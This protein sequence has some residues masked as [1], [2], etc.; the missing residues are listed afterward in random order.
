MKG[1][2]DRVKTLLL[3]A[4][5]AKWQAV[6]IDTVLRGL[7][8]IQVERVLS[9]RWHNHYWVNKLIGR[10]YAAASYIDDWIE[11][12]CDAPQL[13]VDLCN[14]SNLV[15]YTRAR[16]A[17]SEYPL[18]I[19]SHSA[20]GDDMA[21][22]RRTAA[23]FQARRGKLLVFVGNEY[24]LMPTKIGFLNTVQADY[25]GCQL[26][27][28]AAQFLY[29]ECR[30]TQILMTPHALNPKLYYPN[31]TM[32][33]TTDIGFIGD[34]YPY[35][36]G[37]MERTHII[38]Y[39]QEHAAELGLNCDIRFRR[40]QSE[41]WANFLRQCKGI[42]GAEAGTYY[43]ERNDWTIQAVNAYLKEHPDATFAEV[44][45]R[46][47]KNHPRTI[48]GKAISSRHFEPIGTQTCQVLLEGRYNDILVA[49][50]HYIGIKKD[51]S[52]VQEAI[53]RFKDVS[54]RT[55]M[56]KRTFEYAMDKHT[57][58]HRVQSIL[59]IILT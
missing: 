44:F 55:A 16:K 53:D 39:F 49:D 14:I 7:L 19:I 27:V 23:W 30:S 43:L 47:F 33:R 8:R 3:Y 42:I 56:V 35:F 15:E 54:Y 5:G 18:I 17:L 11:A 48:S 1:V 37:D 51:F 41:E 58:R 32:Q 24:D 38:Q 59:Q 20:V 26:T 6:A 40:V 34:R 4:N 31:P 46:F 21:L 45:E 57:Y 25:V 52:N 10:R 2:R 50:E 36:I 9:G 22:L 13:D 29:S 28:E 12:F